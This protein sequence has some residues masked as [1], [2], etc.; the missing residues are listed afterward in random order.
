MQAEA[1]VELAEAAPEQAA[2]REPA[3][4]GALGA[5][6]QLIARMAKPSWPALGA[7]SGMTRIKSAWLG[8]AAYSLGPVGP[9][10]RLRS[11]SR[12]RTKGWG[13][14]D[15]NV[16]HKVQLVPIVQSP[17]EVIRAGVCN[18]GFVNAA[19]CVRSGSTPKV[20]GVDIRTGRQVSDSGS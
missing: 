12:R 3:E 19:R 11:P 15:H 2:E 7:W 8:I 9:N 16:L 17:P 14:D 4:A 13:C 10:M 6:E 20:R 1:A 18:K 5:A